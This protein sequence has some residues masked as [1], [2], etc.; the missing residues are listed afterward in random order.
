VLDDPVMNGTR[1]G[2]GPD[3]GDSGTWATETLPLSVRKELLERDLS[4]LGFRKAGAQAAPSPRES[5]SAQQ[6][7]DAGSSHPSADTQGESKHAR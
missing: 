5:T 6:Q 7:D 1:S 2:G 4:R 3:D